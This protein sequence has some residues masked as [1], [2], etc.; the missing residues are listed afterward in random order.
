M[1]LTEDTL[2]DRVEPLVAAAFGDARVTGLRRLEGGYSSETF[3][4]TLDHGGDARR[5]VL[6]VA[7]VGVAPVRNRDVLRQARVLR[8]LSTDPRV[9]VP[10]V[11]FEDSGEPPDIPPLFAM[12]WID[13]ESL[14]PNLDDV[15]ELPPAAE[16]R[17]RASSASRQLAYLHLVN[18]CA[19]G[20][21]AESALTLSDEITRWDR[22]F[23][24]VPDGLSAGAANCSAALRKSQPRDASPVLIH[25]DFRLG[26]TL[27]RGGEVQAIID[28]EIWSLGD[29]RIDLAWFVMT[30]QPEVHP[31]LVRSAPGMPGA[32]ELVAEYVG[33]GGPEPG[34]LEW[35]LA[36][37]LYKL[38]AT[39]G[40][41]VKRDRRRGIDHGASQGS[42]AQVPVMLE[43][44]NALLK[45]ER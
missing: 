38:A 25:G 15:A 43:R 19:V 5:F 6:K 32:E 37:V 11:I 10:A 23:E 2:R 40:L 7:P 1:N 17:D 34:R 12:S 39:T 31:S 41:L 26:N 27:C 35:F 3:V 30:A 28:W 16:I 24:T 20:P 33:A 22:A 8:A 36:L 4:V 13:G 29:A 21:V 14:E 18:L 9:R 45:G 42:A 44:A